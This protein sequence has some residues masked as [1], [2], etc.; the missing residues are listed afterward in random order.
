MIK[1]TRNVIFDYKE[2]DGN[3][4]NE[5]E[6]YIDENIDDVYDFFNLNERVKTTIHII[7][8]KK[9][10]DD[11]YRKTIKGDENY[12]V[13]DWLV[14]VCHNGYEIYYLSLNDYDNTRHKFDEKDYE[15]NLL[16]YKKTIIHELVHFINALYSETNKVDY[17]E[18]FLAEGIA[19]YLSGQHDGEELKFN[20]SYEDIINN[21]SCYPGRFLVTKYIIDEYGK[22]TYLYFLNNQDEAKKF[23]ANNIDNMREYFQKERIR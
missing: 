17:T 5:L 12:L 21:N 7:E 23:V 9:E 2:S 6:K 3:L 19:Q 15:Y 16:L 14:G 1:N 8:T 22:D 11:F 18:S 20:Y 13:P 4:V 10:F